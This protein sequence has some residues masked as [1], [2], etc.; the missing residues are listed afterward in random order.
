VSYPVYPDFGLA[1]IFIYEGH[2]GGVGITHTGF[3]M[4]DE[5]LG[6]TLRAVATCPCEA[7]CPSCIQSPKCGNL[8][9][10]L[11]KRAAVVLLTGLLRGGAAA[12]QTAESAAG[13]RSPARGAQPAARA[14]PPG[15]RRGPR[16]RRHR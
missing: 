3:A 10:P 5:W 1:T 9:E 6:A 8:N 11:D 15:G 2:P 4:L 13:A 12:S 14:H 16:H 7:G